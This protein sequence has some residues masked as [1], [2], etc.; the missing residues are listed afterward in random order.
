MRIDKNTKIYL[1]QT[2]IV[3]IKKGNVV[4]W[5]SEP[6]VEPDYF[7][8]ES[9]T[10]GSTV[11]LDITISYTGLSEYPTPTIEY[12]TDKQNWSTVTFDW[13]TGNKTISI[14]T[15]LNTG[16]KM[17]FR[18]DTGKFSYAYYY[19]NVSNLAYI[20]FATN[21]NVNV[22]GDIRTLVNYR[23]V[24]TSSITQGMFVYLFENNT[25]IVDA[26]N[27]RLP[28]TTLVSYCYGNMF[29]GCTAL[30]TA[31][32]L[33]AT[34]LRTYCYDGMFLNCYSLTTA[35]A[36][37]ATTLA[38][39]CYNNMFYGCTSLTTAP[40]LPA[41]TLATYCYQSM[42]HGCTS[43]VNAP[44]LPATTLV[45]HCYDSMF[46]NCTALTTAPALPAT[47][48]GDCCYKNMFYGCSA[49]TTAPALPATTLRPYCYTSMFD[50]CTS[51]TTAPAVLPAI[52]LSYYCYSNMFFN[53]TSLTTSPVLQANTL[54]SYC[55]NSM[56]N[57]CSSLNKVLTYADDISATDCTTN[58]LNDVAASGTLYNAGSAV[59]TTDSPSGI[60]TG[61]SEVAAPTTSVYAVPDTF[62]AK[63]WQDKNR[64]DF[65]LMGRTA[66]GID[67][68]IGEMS[69][70]V[71][72][73]KNT[74]SSTVTHTETLTY[75]GMNYTITINQTAND[76]DEP[77]YVC[78]EN[79][80]E[81]GLDVTITSSFS[82][83][84]NKPT[85]G[86]Y[87]ESIEYSLDKENW[88]LVSLVSGS[89]SSRTGVTETITVPSLGKVYFRNDT[90]LFSYYGG[91]NNYFTVS[92]FTNGNSNVS[93]DI[94]TL[95]NYRNSNVD[96]PQGCFA[97]LFG[98][99]NCMIRNAQDLTLSSKTSKYCY[100]KMFS[101]CSNLITTPT[102]PATTLASYCYGYMFNGCTALTTAPALPAT[103]LANNC[104]YNM[105]SVCHLL[106]TAPELPATTLADYCYQ[107][108]FQSCTSLTT[109]PALPATTL[110]SSCYGYM[111]NGCT[112][113]T[114]AP[115]LPATTLADYCYQY[116]FQNCTS[117][118]TA[119]ALPATTLASYCY[120]YMF[121]NCTSLTTAPALPATTLESSCY[122]NMFNGCTALTTAPALPA[123]TLRTYCYDG[124]FS[125]CT[126]LTIAPA[127]P[128]T[129]L[130][131]SCYI[132]MFKNC[133]N[134]N[135]VTSY[136]TTNVTTSC[137][138]SWL[139]N[140]SSTGTFNNCG[141]ATYPSGNS[142]IPTG[143]TEVFP[144]QSI[145]ANPDTF[146]LKSYQTK[147]RCESTLTITTTFGTTVTK[148]NLV[149]LTVGENTGDSTR[150]LTET[151]PY[152]GSSYQVTIVQTANDPAPAWSWSVTTPA[153][154]Y[155]F[156][157]N[158]NDYYESNNKGVNSSYAYC[159]LNYSGFDNLILECINYG[160]NKYD[161][162]I[163][164]QPDVLLSESTTDDSNGA[165]GTATVFKNF[166]TESSATPV[167]LTIPSDGGSHFI[168]IK[169]KKD[170]STAAGND[171]LQF[172]VV[173]PTT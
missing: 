53:C 23:D 114:T 18:N 165:S 76:T 45:N 87:T 8:I 63:S 163:I 6:A 39:Y 82:S 103:T 100:Y 29:N 32:A 12:S 89:G 72:I 101:S 128:A 2:E 147:V 159:T 77:D 83:G 134:L 25:N 64:C 119:P 68:T 150:T 57:G 52:T 143:W 61:W 162:G 102:L 16:D 81:S 146:T 70:L 122:S 42:F 161:Y 30:T 121:Q 15:V 113:L 14:P 41:T 154:G 120:Q 142:G 40:A 106:T 109:A 80:T 149:V 60:P 133:S 62:S 107:Y 19:N 48:L 115:A 99:G 160:E 169:Y 164:S 73:G 131:T 17:Y 50:G 37:P 116:M 123:T 54:A 33:P 56:F 172:R 124:M 158:L 140:V 151:I 141:F 112:S 153:S 10:D 11:S 170:G 28:Y 74:G 65:T 148:T 75:D 86:T 111:F 108:M 137:L 98:S 69:E 136:A 59:Y 51:L 104:Y 126:S 47:T 78:I 7:Y 130:V 71:T 38:T 168:T 79:T 91:Y 105:F 49:L 139:Q 90:G 20:K 125:G 110:E 93:G 138:S 135:S 9:L 129:T 4:I 84:Y 117:L 3:K 171:S 35:P 95:L 152:K 155:T 132:N 94:T 118:T 144:I 127:L 27:L 5:E 88:T 66:F 67:I 46:I 58:W 44:A 96:Y 43:L 31:P 156:E 21:K 85:E 22:G 24:E 36:L 34:T 55:Y 173:E 92:I 167:Q 13:S 26:S 157:L 1:G 97:L 145:T 166:K